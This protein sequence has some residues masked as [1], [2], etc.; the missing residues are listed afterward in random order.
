LTTIAKQLTPPKN[1]LKLTFI[2]SSDNLDGEV[3]LNSLLPAIELIGNKLEFRLEYS[4]S[5]HSA[6]IAAKTTQRC[7]MN[8]C[9]QKLYPHKILRYL[10]CISQLGQSSNQCSEH[11]HFDQG[12]LNKCAQGKKGIKLL[13]DSQKILSD[14]TNSLPIIMINDNRYNGEYSPSK[15]IAAICALSD[16]SKPKICHSQSLSARAIFLTDHRCNQC[17]QVKEVVNYLQKQI[18]GLKIAEVDY[19]SSQGKK[20]FNQLNLELLPQL[21]FPQKIKHND[22]AWNLY[23]QSLKPRGKFYTF[24]KIRPFYNPTDNSSSGNSTCNTK[25]KNPGDNSSN[26]Q[27]EEPGKLQL[28]IRPRCPFGN[29]VLANTEKLFK[30]I[31]GKI[32]FQLS[33]LLEIDKSGKVKS[34]YGGIT[35]SKRQLCAKHHYP[36][37]HKYIEYIWCRAHQPDDPDW[38]K[39]TTNTIKANVIKKCVNSSQ[40]SK[41]LKTNLQS[42]KNR[43]ISIS[44]SLI[45]NNKHIYTGIK[46]KQLKE[47]FCKHN[48]SL[49]KSKFTK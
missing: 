2:L 12:R 10:S 42:G 18:P 29:S 5:R 13:A 28:F 20:L 8:L 36:H 14:E 32:N 1:K 35:E 4:K 45:I 21:L 38:K 39:C 17:K 44:P 19:C 37:D 3:A 48:R 24:N 34:L 7:I 41:L 46:P 27:K 33:Y 49:C 16:K 40:A 25:T 23:R 15:F 47:L 30:K 9:V 22:L 31:P 6:A 11:F 26:N 43:G